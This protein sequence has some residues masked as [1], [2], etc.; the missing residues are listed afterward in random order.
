MIETVFQRAFG[1]APTQIVKTPGRVNLIGE[2][3]DYNG[4]MVLPTAIDLSL[5]LAFRLRTDDFIHVGS[6]NFSEIVETTVNSPLEKNW[7]AYAIGAVAAARQ[8][9]MMNRGADIYITSSIPDGAGLSSSAALIV[10]ILKAASLGS[11]TTITD[12]EIALLAQRVENEFIGVPCGVMDQMAVSLARPGQAM[13]L[14]TKTL[15]YELIDLP[16]GHHMAVV[17]SGQHR[18]LA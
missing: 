12:R 14:D 3:T 7:A 18:R 10:S 2:H 8:T 9:K 6:D 13:A 11:G 5:T 15:D 4:G 1:A 17:H 16:A